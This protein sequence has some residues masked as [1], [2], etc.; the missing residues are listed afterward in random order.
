MALLRSRKPGRTELLRLR[1]PVGW[2]VRSWVCCLRLE[3]SVDPQEKM[4]GRPRSEFGQ[5]KKA[6]G[7]RVRCGTHL[8]T[9][10]RGEN[11]ES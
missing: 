5:H 10:E 3:M 6:L 11:P 1:L 8:H 4:L 2:A 9:D 7:W